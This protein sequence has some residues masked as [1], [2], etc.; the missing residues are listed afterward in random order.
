MIAGHLPWRA[1]DSRAWREGKAGLKVTWHSS[2]R[3]FTIGARL[4]CAISRSSAEDAEIEMRDKY[5]DENTLR[6]VLFHPNPLWPCEARN[7]QWELAITDKGIC[8]SLIRLKKQ[9]TR[10][11]QGVFERGMLNPVPAIA[12]FF[13]H[14]IPNHPET[15]GNQD[16]QRLKKRCFSTPPFSRP[17]P[18]S[19]FSCEFLQVHR[20]ALL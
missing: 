16:A 17:T 8:V 9:R 18:V 19:W 1:R 20:S 10:I 4:F 6:F 13:S 7:G 15:A 2:R 3:C 14:A 12:E 5:K 11:E